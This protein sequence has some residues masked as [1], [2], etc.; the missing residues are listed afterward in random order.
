MKNEENFDNFFGDFFG[1][2]FFYLKNLILIFIQQ[3]T[4]ADLS[5]SVEESSP[6]QIHPDL[7]RELIEAAFKILERDP[8]VKSAKREI[9]PVESLAPLPPVLP[10]C[11]ASNPSEAP[12][13]SGRRAVGVAQN[14]YTGQLHYAYYPSSYYVPTTYVG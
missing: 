4:F 5:D 3:L 9:A 8:N 10:P 2:I 1:E 14:P 11:K 12:K 13:G 6:S 7:A